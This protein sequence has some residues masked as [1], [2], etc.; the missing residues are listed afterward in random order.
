MSISNSSIQ[1]YQDIIVHNFNI[2]CEQ[3]NKKIIFQ[4]KLYKVFYIA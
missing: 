3:F 4:L 2:N 1:G